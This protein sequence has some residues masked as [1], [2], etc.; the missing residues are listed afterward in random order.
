MI[1]PS[2][3]AVFNLVLSTTGSMPDAPAE[4]VLKGVDEAEIWIVSKKPRVKIETHRGFT[5]NIDFATHGALSLTNLCLDL[6]T[7]PKGLTLSFDPGAGMLAVDY[8][9]EKGALRVLFGTGH[10]PVCSIP[11]PLTVA[12]TRVLLRQREQLALY[13]IPQNGEH[14]TLVWLGTV[15]DV[16]VFRN[17]SQYDLCSNLKIAMGKRD[18]PLEEFRKGIKM[19]AMDQI[20]D[21]TVTGTNPAGGTF[22]HRYAFDYAEIQKR[23]DVAYV[24]FLRAAGNTLLGGE[25]EEKPKGML[26][27]A[28]G[29]KPGVSP[30]AAAPDAES[31]PAASPMASPS[32]P[33]SPVASPVM[34]STANP[35]ASPSTSAVPSPVSGTSAP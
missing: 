30:D 28:P 24:N 22:V 6:N 15:S 13:A 25:E 12:T 17:A 11:L 16:L 31:T 33:S 10:T 5:F 26:S 23:A 29:A 4:K 3:L 14:V 1:F 9:K 20:E 27:P 35:A 18:I 32:N 8:D 7:Q 19:T 21:V 2:L 34:S